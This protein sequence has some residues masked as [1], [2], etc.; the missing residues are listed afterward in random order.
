M[1]DLE[2]LRS[3]VALA[4]ELRK[5]GVLRV[6]CG[7]LSLELQPETPE[8]QEPDGEKKHAIDRMQFPS[9]GGPDKQPKQVKGDQ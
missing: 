9:F 8:V 4:N 6:Q 1:S 3:I 2:T 7:S 5:A